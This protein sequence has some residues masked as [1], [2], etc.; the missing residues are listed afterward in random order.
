M[1]IYTCA[2]TYI[3]VIPVQSVHVKL[4]VLTSSPANMPEA[5]QWIQYTRFIYL[6]YSDMGHVHRALDEVLKQTALYTEVLWSLV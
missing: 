6:F 5:S 3:H 4:P 1:Y 2:Y